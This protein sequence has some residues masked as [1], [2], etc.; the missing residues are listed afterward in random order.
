MSPNATS[1]Q[2]DLATKAEGEADY[3]VNATG[4]FT[5]NA[6]LANDITET[7]TDIE[8]SDLQSFDSANVGQALYIGD[9]LVRLDALDENTSIATV[10]RG[11]G[12]TIP[13]LHAADTRVWTID[14]DLTNDGRAYA[15]GETVYAKVLT[16]ISS[17]SLSLDDAPE[18]SIELIGRQGRPYPPAD[19]QVDGESIYTVSGEHGEPVLTWASRNRITQADQLVGH[20]DASV[21]AEANT[22]YTVRV[23]S[24]EDDVTPIREVTGIT[25]LTWTYDAA[26]QVTDNPP[27]AVRMELESERDGITSW[28]HYSFIVVLQSGWGYGWG[29]NWGGA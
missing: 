16:R 3:E 19:V 23:Y 22:T 2:Y 21:A 25:D 7:Q 11:V 29:L 27:S 17:D 9:E 20:F 18:E 1:Y 8:L 14:D 4:S 12:D 13:Q 28:Q 24:L 10:T 15:E 26:M 6:K 5:G